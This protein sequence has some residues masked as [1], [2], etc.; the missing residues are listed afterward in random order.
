MNSIGMATRSALVRHSERCLGV[1]HRPS[2]ARDIV[3]AINPIP[4]PTP[5]GKNGKWIDTSIWPLAAAYVLAL[6]IVF[7]LMVAQSLPGATQ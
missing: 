4:Q 5:H 2:S 7:V 1:G 6:F 3:C